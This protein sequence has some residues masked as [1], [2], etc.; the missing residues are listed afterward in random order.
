MADDQRWLDD[1]EK[2]AWIP[3]VSTLL[4]LPSALD[5]QLQQDSGLTFYEY[6]VLAALSEAGEEGFRISDLAAVTS[7]SQPRLSQVATR[8]EQRGWVARRSDPDDRRS[9]RVTIRPAGQ[10][11][12][13]EAA[14]RHADTVRRLVFDQLTPSQVGQLERIAMRI[15]S[16]LVPP[17]SLIHA[18]RTFIANERDR[19]G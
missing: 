18:R 4:L 19:S 1:A 8:L 2:A 9:T 17:D 10:K 11:V 7:A 16:T 14:P 3:L 13:A 15:A 5:A 6:V 12:L